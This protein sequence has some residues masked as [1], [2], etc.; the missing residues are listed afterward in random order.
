MGLQLCKLLL[1]RV[2]R[3]C[4]TSILQTIVAGD[5]VAVEVVFHL[6][7]GSLHEGT[8][9]EKQRVGECIRSSKYADRL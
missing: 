8:A 3:K 7:N 1:K 4:R 9:Q 6:H 2:S 5:C